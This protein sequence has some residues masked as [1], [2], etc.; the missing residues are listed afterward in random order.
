MVEALK[1]E[2]VEHIFREYGGKGRD[3]FHVFQC[4]IRS[5]AAKEANDDECAFFKD[6]I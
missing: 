1:K 6:L 3:L 5:D 4:D 2:G